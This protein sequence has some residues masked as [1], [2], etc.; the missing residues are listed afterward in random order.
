MILFPH[1]KQRIYE[2]RQKIKLPFDAPK[3]ATFVLFVA[4]LCNGAANLFFMEVAQKKNIGTMNIFAITV[5]VF[6]LVIYT[7]IFARKVT[8]NTLLVNMA[9][10]FAVLN[11]LIGC[12]I[13]YLVI[14]LRNLF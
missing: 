11:T 14:G 6:V 13:K 10:I 9:I 4:R 1:N 12:E 2:L 5:I 8:L 7:L 3:F